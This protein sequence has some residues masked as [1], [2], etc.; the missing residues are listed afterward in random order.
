[1]R[2][3]ARRGSEGACRGMRVVPRGRDADDRGARSA[4]DGAAVGGARCGKSVGDIAD[5]RCGPSDGHSA[6]EDREFRFA[7][8]WRGAAVYGAFFRY[9]DAETEVEFLGLVASDRREPGGCRPG[10]RARAK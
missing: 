8:W 3:G 7:S 2:R 4:E 6:P 10:A 9:I 5:G 1:M